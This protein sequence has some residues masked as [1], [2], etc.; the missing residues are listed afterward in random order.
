M[1]GSQL[2][3]NLLSKAKEA[4]DDLVKTKEELHLVMTTPPPPPPPVYEP[5][6]YHVQE[7]PQE[8]GTEYTGYSAELSSEGIL[9]DRNEEKRITEAEKNERVQRQ[10]RVSGMR[11]GPA[12]P[13]GWGRGLRVGPRADRGCFALQTLTSELSQARDENKRTHN[14]IIHNENM[15]QGRDK[16]KTLRQ[17]R[18][19]N[20]K[21]RIDEFEAM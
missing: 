19:G 2:S 16:Y 14:D 5:V 7:N 18:Q 1:K 9:D 21:Q 20:T 3:I 17:I 8:E 15:R 11:A 10:L 4:Q 12:F 13:T 6:N